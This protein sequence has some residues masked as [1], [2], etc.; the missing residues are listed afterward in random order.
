MSKLFNGL[1]TLLVIAGLCLPS[2]TDPTQVGSDLLEEDEINVG[3]I[4]TLTMVSSTETGDTVR[5]Y[6]P[7]IDLQL[8]SYLFGNFI[9]PVFGQS[10]SEIYVRPRLQRASNG[11]SLVYPDFEDAVLDSVVLILRYDS[12]AFYGNFEETF[13]M[14]VRE[15]TEMIDPSEDYYSNSSFSAD[16][17]I[18]AEHEFVPDPNDSTEVYYYFDGEADTLKFDQLR[19]PLPA[20]FGQRF[21]DADTSVYENDSTFLEYFKGLKLSPTK[22]TDGLI[23]FDFGGFSVANAQLTGIYVYYHVDTVPGHYQFQINTFSTKVAAF[24][25]DP[26]GAFVAPFIDNSDAVDSLVFIQ[27]ME[28]LYTRVDFPY[29]S[30]LKGLIINKAELEFDIAS[31]SGDDPMRYAPVEQLIVLR[32]NEDGELRVI[33]DVT[34]ASTNLPASLGG[35]VVA[36]SDGSPDF[37]RLNITSHFQDMI[38]GIEPNILYFSA[39]PR[40]ERANRVVLYGA[41]HQEFPIRLKLYF[42]KP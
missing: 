8:R 19:V 22:E 20:S 13:G 15:V 29:V 26:T 42:T 30:D 17:Q 35:V 37:Y 23:A 33:S 34:F 18:I 11:V 6:S 32:K 38:D 41:N 16:N 24:D 36:G 21:I 2:C 5:T 14:E 7:D 39:F 10:K 12:S 28:G 1:F 27:S 25:N 3:F 40:A 31:V 9:D 4:D